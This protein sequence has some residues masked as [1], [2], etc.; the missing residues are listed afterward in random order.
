MEDKNYHRTILVN[1]T[2][3][4]A[5]NKISQINIQKKIQLQLILPILV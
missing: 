5:M 2:V 1:A 4:V 3:E